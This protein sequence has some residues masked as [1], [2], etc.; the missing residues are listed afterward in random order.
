MCICEFKL[1][2]N[3]QQYVMTT[4]NDD[5]KMGIGHRNI[6]VISIVNFACVYLLF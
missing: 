4:S 2:H 3:C 1:D 5:I 6:V